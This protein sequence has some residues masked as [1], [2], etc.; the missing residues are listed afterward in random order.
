[1]SSAECKFIRSAAVGASAVI[2]TAFILSRPNFLQTYLQK[3]IYLS[4]SSAKL[5]KLF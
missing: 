5:K 1:V 4:F 2:T 3:T